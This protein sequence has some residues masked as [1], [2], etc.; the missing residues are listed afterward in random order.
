[1]S[2]TSIVV[3]VIFITIIDIHTYRVFNYIYVYRERDRVRAQFLKKGFEIYKFPSDRGRL[4]ERRFIICLNRELGDDD[5]PSHA[6]RFDYD[7]A[8]I[9]LLLPPPPIP[10]IL[11]PPL[12]YRTHSTSTAVRWFRFNY[13]I[14]Y[15]LFIFLNSF[16]A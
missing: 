11:L 16:V 13:R 12:S 14:P 5:V 8:L 1:M 3:V 4:R 10:A 15:Y 6:L 2:N 7:T 9:T